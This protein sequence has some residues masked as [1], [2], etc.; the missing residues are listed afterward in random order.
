[1][2]WKSYRDQWVSEGFSNYMALLYLEQ[3]H[4]EARAGE[5]LAELA[6]R[7]LARSGSGRSY[8][9]NGPVW[10]GRRLATADVPDGYENA[11][12]PKATWIVH[13]LRTLMRDAA[14]GSDEGFFRM[15]REYLGEFAG[16]PATTW[17]LKSVAERHMTPRMD[18]E[19]DGTLDWFFDQWVFSTG[20]PDYSLEYEVAPEPASFRVRGRIRD[21][22]GLDFLVPLPLVARLVTGEVR[23]LGDVVVRE[24]AATFEFTLAE[25][26]VEIL[27]DPDRSVLR[28]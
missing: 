20:V 23:E 1:V 17:D 13:M 10:L 24:G 2:S 22:Q 18:L 3:S 26:P 28:R 4:G 14:D 9:D 16:G 25:R 21:R 15:V 27:M 19:G 11:V 8:D 12:Y 5:I 6:D 7:L